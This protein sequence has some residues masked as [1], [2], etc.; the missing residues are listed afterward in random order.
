[1]AKKQDDKLPK[2][3]EIKPKKKGLFSF[4]RRKSKSE[5]AQP[6]LVDDNTSS[7]DATSASKKT[8]SKRKAVTKNSGTANSDKA[9]PKKRGRQKKQPTEIIDV[10]TEVT[11]DEV[12]LKKKRS[13]LGLFK[14]KK[15]P[16]KD[17]AESDVKAEVENK[18]SEK[19]KKKP[20]KG[21]ASETAKA[22]AKKRGQPKK[23]AEDI[24]VA[25][26][27]TAEDLAEESKK[28]EGFFAFLKRKKKNDNKTERVDDAA[29]TK[30][31]AVDISIPPVGGEVLQMELNP[32][33]EEEA[34]KKKSGFFTKK[35]VTIIVALCGVS[36]ATGAAAIVFAGP[37]LGD[38]PS[39]GLACKVAHKA[40]FVL[41]KEKRV[42]AFIRSDL[43]PPRQRIEMLMRYTKFLETEYTG[44]NLITVS[45]LDTQG[46]MS[47]VNFRGDNV[48]AQIV[49]APDPLLS[50]AT[51][52]KWEVRYVNVS[53][54]NGGRFMGDR[55]TL[56]E[57]EINEFNNDL[58]LAADCY[59]EKTDEELEA[60]EL[61]LEEAAAE[62]EMLT[63]EVEGEYQNETT[64]GEEQAENAEPG[65]IDNM[66]GMVGLGGSDHSEDAIDIAQD[67][68]RQIYPGDKGPNADVMHV[69]PDFFDDVLSIVGLGGGDDDMHENTL[70]GV[71]GTRVKYN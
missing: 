57:D 17:T 60:E 34:Q 54:T 7:T 19:G 1:M 9:Q 65:F 49:Y 66:L 40:D 5:N 37:L 41:M 27:E 32:G 33:I 58:L 67:D 53:E 62:A 25:A 26:S 47:R 52:T 30:E 13:F 42:T 18:A 28:K 6:E 44:A 46:P 14:S 45:M 3:G 64:D 2:D 48:G 69:E 59:M 22:P 4:L 23:N 21:K 24:K 38:D 39:R 8:N 71:L 43:L 35:V 55:F 20:V 11:G 50:M 63:Q 31:K 15:K 12:S 10:D 36:G 16:A 29:V 61:A 68:G 56:S 70:P 51:D